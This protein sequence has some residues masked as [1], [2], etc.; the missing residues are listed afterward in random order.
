MT[1]WV[2]IVLCIV[3]KCNIVAPVQTYSPS[4]SIEASTDAFKFQKNIELNGPWIVTQ[5]LKKH[6]LLYHDSTIYKNNLGGLSDLSRYKTTIVKIVKTFLNSKVPLHV[7][8][9]IYNLAVVLEPYG[10]YGR[11]DDNCNAKL[12]NL[13]NIKIIKHTINYTEAH[14]VKGVGLTMA[15]YNVKLLGYEMDRLEKIADQIVNNLKA[16]H[17]VALIETMDNNETVMALQYLIDKINELSNIQYNFNFHSKYKG[18]QKKTL[19]CQVL[20]YRIDYF[21]TVQDQ[22]TIK[23]YHPTARD[24]LVCL[25][26]TKSTRYEN[27]QS[28]VFIAS[29]FASMIKASNEQIRLDQATAIITEI[30]KLKQ[31]YSTI[32]LLGD[33]ND[34]PT[35]KSISL[36][37]QELYDLTSITEHTYIYKGLSNRLDGIFAWRHGQFIDKFLLMSYSLNINTITNDA[38]SDHDPVVAQ[39]I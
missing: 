26:L 30:H 11:T 15:T 36:L 19:I 6:L 22:Y 13:E 33:F 14:F 18:D 7:G 27:S 2:A 3:F 12:R 35:S 16:P 32:V 10:Q 4:M 29:H 28:I 31:K 5:V 21:I 39:I 34:Y 17:V 38:V 20:L 25:L 1:F 9:K 24:S 37:Q 23:S 8:D